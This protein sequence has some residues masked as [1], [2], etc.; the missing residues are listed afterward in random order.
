MKYLSI[1]FLLIA[2]FCCVA[3]D[4]IRK[5]TANNEETYIRYDKLPYA[6]YDVHNYLA[7]HIIFPKNL[8]DTL[9]DKKV[10]V[11][12]NVKDDGSIDNVKIVKSIHHSIDTNIITTVSGMPK[13]KPAEH[14][15]KKVAS[16]FVLPIYITLE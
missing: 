2:H 9:L 3:Q 14:K 13:W 1:I 5:K 4:T 12:F 6:D 8:T 15:G 10:I 7:K 16:Q 11:S